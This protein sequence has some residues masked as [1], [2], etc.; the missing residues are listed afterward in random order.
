[1]S[2]SYHTATQAWHCTVFSD[3]Q[4]AEINN[5]AEYG[6]PFSPYQSGYDHNHVPD[7]GNIIIQMPQSAVMNGGYGRNI[8]T[9]DFPLV[10]HFLD[11]GVM[12]GDTAYMPQIVE[13]GADAILAAVGAIPRLP[14]GRHLLSTLIARGAVRDRDRFITTNLY[15][16]GSYGITA[17]SISAGDAAYIHGTVSF[18]LKRNTA[19]IVTSTERRVEAEIGAGDDNW[20]FN[21]STINPVVN[22]TVATL[23]GPDHYNLTAPI[24]MQF[25]G[26]GKRMT[27]TKRI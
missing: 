2:W 8:T 13:R 12:M 21:S 4:Y 3:L 22:A 5:F 15:G 18:A 17:G 20:D 14:S 16:W 1:M 23:L 6:Q 24:K 27:A 19:F 10:N 7:F 25:R 11:N 9:L 26:T